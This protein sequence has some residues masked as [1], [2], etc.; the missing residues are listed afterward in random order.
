MKNNSIINYFAG[1]WLELKKVS[2]PTKKEVINHTIIVIVSAALATMIAALLDFGLTRLV[3]FIV[4]NK[5]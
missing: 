3:E 2:W 1:V 5:I 4:E